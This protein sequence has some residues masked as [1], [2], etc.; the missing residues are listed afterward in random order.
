MLDL[1]QQEESR[2]REVLHYHMKVRIWFQ[3]LTK[4]SATGENSHANLDRIYYQTEANAGEYDVPPAF[5]RADLPVFGYNDYPLGVPT[6]GTTCKGSCPD[7]PDCECEHQI[8]YRWTL[9]NIRLIYAGAHCHA[10]S[11]ISITLYINTTGT[12]EPLC[13][14]IGQYGK[15]NFPADKFDEKNYLTIP[16]CL[17]SDDPAEGLQ[18]TV[19]LPKDTPVVSIKKNRNTHMGHFGEMASWQMRGVSFQSPSG[20][21]SL[22]I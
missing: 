10:P 4:D 20:P 13:S 2:K 5:A 11:C 15:G 17:W 21:Q 7:G 14:Q 12:L 22:L 16:P 19:W 18:P 9:S 3:E 1:E 8:M 6:P